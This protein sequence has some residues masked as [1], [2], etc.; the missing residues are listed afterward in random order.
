LHPLSR[1]RERVR[2]RVI[3]LK[4]VFIQRTVPHPQPFSRR[5]ERGVNSGIEI[6]LELTTFSRLNYES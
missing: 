6:E 4:N 1:K 3:E 5:R 2:E